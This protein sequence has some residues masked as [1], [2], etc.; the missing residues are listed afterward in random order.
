MRKEL[1]FCRIRIR[2]DVPPG[3]YRE[4]MTHVSLR[5]G[6]KVDNL[7]PGCAGRA[8]SAPQGGLSAIQPRNFA[9]LVMAASRCTKVIFGALSVAGWVLGPGL[10]GPGAGF[11]VPGDGFS[12]WSRVVSTGQVGGPESRPR[13]QERFHMSK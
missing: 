8:G 2:D 12:R 6:G 11:H 5:P 9:T 10:P 7:G 4:T 13:R 3:L 1:P